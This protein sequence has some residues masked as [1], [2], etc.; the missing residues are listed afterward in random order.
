MASVENFNQIVIQNA[1]FKAAFE[2]GD[3]NEEQYKEA[4]TYQNQNLKILLNAGTI[5]KA[6]Y[7]QVIADEKIGGG[8]T[9]SNPITATLTQTKAG[10]PLYVW[11]IVAVV[12]GIGIVA[13]IAAARGTK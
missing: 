9:S 7:D 12:A 13:V 5:T 3:I 6:Q 11:L 8:A 4:I 1:N 10:L 2:D